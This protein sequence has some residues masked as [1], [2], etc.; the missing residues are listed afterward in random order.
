MLNRSHGV[1]LGLIAVIEL[2]VPSLTRA[3]SPSE[4]LHF[5]SVVRARPHGVARTLVPSA[6]IAVS[7][8]GR[9]PPRIGAQSNGCSTVLVDQV[10][11]ALYLL[12]ES[13]QITERVTSRDGRT[14]E[15]SAAHGN[16]LPWDGKH[17]VRMPTSST[18]EFLRIACRTNEVLGLAMSFR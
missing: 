18:H 5:P 4:S 14:T 3:Q 1:A 2:F 11:G 7:P 10:R 16:Y 13:Q 17:D 15:V 9:T 12:M 6:T 8:D